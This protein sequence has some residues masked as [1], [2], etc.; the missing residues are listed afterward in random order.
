MQTR[1]FRQILQ[2]AT[3]LF[4]EGLQARFAKM[5][6]Y[7]PDENR[8]IVRAGVGWASGTIDIISLSADIE[9]SAGFAYLCRLAKRNST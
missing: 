7:L 6:E 3:E 4:A 5:L 8:L 2:H 9:S 1:N